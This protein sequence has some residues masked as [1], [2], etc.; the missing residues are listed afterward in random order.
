MKWTRY[1]LAT[2]KLLSN[3]ATSASVEDRIGEG[4]GVIEGWHDPAR[5]IVV[6]GALV[7]IEPEQPFDEAENEA[8][9]HRDRLLVD[10]DWTQLPDAPVD[11]A[12][13]AIYRQ[14]L[15]DLPNHPAW[16]NLLTEDWPS[17]PVLD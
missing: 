8:R 6:D 1:D 3:I 5:F 4:E 13:W 17:V 9:L 15:R 16:P 10:S 7:E 14:A 12:A 11:K 2:G